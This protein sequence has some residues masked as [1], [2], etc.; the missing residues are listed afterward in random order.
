M[1]GFLFY[2]ELVIDALKVHN[3][4]FICSGCLEMAYYLQ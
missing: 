3:Y 1:S 2:S 4:L